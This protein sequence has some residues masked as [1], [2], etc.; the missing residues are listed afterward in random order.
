[1]EGVAG[2]VLHRVI[3]EGML[4]VCTDFSRAGEADVVFICVPTPIT[5]EKNPEM[6]H[7][8]SAA[9]AWDSAFVRDS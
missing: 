1:M 3:R 9:G 8:E 4:E 7:I 6:R 2:E 5:T